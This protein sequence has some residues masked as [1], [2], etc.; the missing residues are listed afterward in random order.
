MIVSDPHD[1]GAFQ[2]SKFFRWVRPGRRQSAFFCSAGTRARQACTRAAPARWPGLDGGGGFIPSRAG[3]AAR[4]GSR[5]QQR[6]PHAVPLCPACSCSFDWFLWSFQVRRAHL[7]TP[8][9]LHLAPPFQCLVAVSATAWKAM[10]T[11]QEGRVS[12]WYVSQVPK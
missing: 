6:L 5:R 4:R 2:C 9:R 8:L 7:C 10:R 1:E 11:G 3:L 12:S